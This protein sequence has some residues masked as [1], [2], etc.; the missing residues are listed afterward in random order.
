MK[1]NK[2]IPVIIISTVL[3]VALGFLIFYVGTFFPW[4]FSTNSLLLLNSI[5][6]IVARWPMLVLIA[7]LLTVEF[8]NRSQ[9]RFPFQGSS[10]VNRLV[11]ILFVVSIIV[12][13]LTKGSYRSPVLLRNES[14]VVQE[15]K[16]GIWQNLEP[17]AV[18]AVVRRNTRQYCANII[19]F[20]GLLSVTLADSRLLQRL[21]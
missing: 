6:K 7:L 18:E 20:F 2:R 19:F 16:D 11:V 5:L 15:F 12:M 10:P 1:I 13:I 4:N 3:T 17:Q 21:G 8:V 14:N 9:N